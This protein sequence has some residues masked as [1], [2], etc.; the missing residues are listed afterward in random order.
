VQ[1]TV[2]EI[3]DAPTTPVEALLSAPL[4]RFMAL[5]ISL[6]AVQVAVVVQV[7]ETAIINIIITCSK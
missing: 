1:I 3:R 5:E 2:V 7:K 6:Q 4:L